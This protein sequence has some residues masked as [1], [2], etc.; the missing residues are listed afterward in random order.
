MHR[1]NVLRQHLVPGPDGTV[2]TSN[3]QA[4]STAAAPAAAATGKIKSFTKSD[5]LKQRAAGRCWIVLHDN[6]YDVTDFLQEHPGGEELITD[7]KADDFETQTTEFDDA[8]HSEEAM[9]QLQEFFKGKLVE[10]DDDDDDSAAAAVVAKPASGAAGDEDE[11]DD[12]EGDEAPTANVGDPRLPFLEHTELSL[13]LIDKQQ[14]SRDVTVF[15]FGLAKTDHQFSLAI[16][17]HILLSFVAQDTK[18]VVSRAYTPVSPFGDTGFV[19]FLIKLYPGGKM[20]E[21][22][23]TLNIGD[24]IK[25]KGPKGKL[26]YEGRGQFRIRRHGQDEVVQLRHG[27]WALVCVRARA[28]WLT[29]VLVGMVAGGSG[30]TPM[31]QVLQAVAADPDDDLQITLLFANK[32]EA[33]IILREPLDAINAQ[34]PGQIRVLYCLDNPPPGWTG[35]SGFITRDMLQQAMP[36][37]EPDVMVFLCGPPCVFVQRA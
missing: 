8:D 11:E 6:V 28:H 18:K 25:M 17:K 5:V 4:N 2:R 27:A 16:G 7:I 15:R 20:S 1:V 26:G 21:H 34:R 35:C 32:T 33:D 3:M 9:E 23:L 13:P 29:R 22:L 36:P 10:G 19:D 24:E 12:E 37:P 31:F 30:I 14:L